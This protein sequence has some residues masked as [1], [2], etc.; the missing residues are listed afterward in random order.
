VILGAVAI[1]VPLFAFFTWR[2]FS[3]HKT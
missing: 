2:M 3:R 1:L